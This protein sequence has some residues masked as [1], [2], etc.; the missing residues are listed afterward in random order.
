MVT[1]ITTTA[2]T[3]TD[4]TITDTTIIGTRPPGAALK[5]FYPHRQKPA[6]GLFAVNAG[7]GGTLGARHLV[8]PSEAQVAQRWAMDLKLR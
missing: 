7:C 6:F 5:T 2:I 4:I 1:I 8:G 3:I